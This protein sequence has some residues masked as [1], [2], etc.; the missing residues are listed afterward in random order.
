M[1]KP[2][3]A[4]GI[5]LTQCFSFQSFKKRLQHVGRNKLPRKQMKIVKNANNCDIIISDSNF[6]LILLKT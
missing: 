3:T 1:T 6:V 4:G 2:V 5:A